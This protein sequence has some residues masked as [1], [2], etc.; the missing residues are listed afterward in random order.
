MCIKA[1]TLRVKCLAKAER[2]LSAR[3][4]VRTD[5]NG[6][7]CALLKVQ[8]AQPNAEFKGLTV[9]TVAYKTSEYQ[10][11]L[12]PLAKNIRISL[13]GY[14]PLDV[15]FN[16]YGYPKL[17]SRSTYIMVVELP[18]NEN[19]QHNPGLY[20]LSCIDLFKYLKKKEYSNLEIWV[21][22]YEIYCNKLFDLLNN[23]NV[24]QAREDGKGHICIAGL[25]EK[26]AKNLNELMA[27]ID[28][29]LSHRKAGITGANLDSSRS[30]AILQIAL[31]TVDKEPYS[32]ISF[33]DLAGSER[34]VDTIDTTKQ[35]KIDGAEINK[36]LLALKECIRALD[37]EKRHKPFRGSK[38]TLVLRDSFIGDCQTLMIANI[39]PCLSCSLHTLN[40]LRYAD[41]VKELRKPRH[42][43]EKE[44]ETEYFNEKKKKEKDIFAD[45]IN[46]PKSNDQNVK[47]K[48][49]L[50][51]SATN[52]NSQPNNLIMD[53]NY[54]FLKIKANKNINILDVDKDIQK[55]DKNIIKIDDIIKNGK[56][57]SKYEFKKN[58]RNSSENKKNQIIF[59]NI[60]N[61][62]I[63]NEDNNAK[64]QYIIM[65]KEKENGLS[66]GEIRDK[67]HDNNKITNSIY[68]SS[69]K[70]KESELL[71]NIENDELNIDNYVSKYN[72]I[73]IKDDEDYRQ[74]SSIHEKLINNIL[75][76]EDIFISDH[77]THIDSMVESIK[78]EMKFLHEVDKPGSDIEEY[79]SNLDKLLI[80]EIKKIA[81]LRTKLNKFRI[82]LKDEETLANI[83]DDEVI[84]STSDG[85]KSFNEQ[86][87][88]SL[89]DDLGNEGIPNKPKYKFEKK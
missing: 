13:Q 22:F 65:N 17:D 61:N 85:R 23:K 20:L 32:K 15:V 67:Y 2:D 60:I 44:R 84:L 29:G 75:K 7:D 81:Q 24:L 10:V 49:E 77:K 71:K 48:I 16:D 3:I 78:D 56:I 58:K 45:L 62:Y 50:K 25:I 36:S 28:H 35:N 80:N 21:S 53:H 66:K 86:S 4:N 89:I 14:L 55:P 51:R 26:N 40:T 52:A 74:L 59:N 30:H 1:Q 82:M 33:I 70:E 27:L 18:N 46:M 11:Y 9:G 31:K 57:P 12:S 41:R 43:R 87:Q 19:G 88:E 42:E 39:S 73:E 34:A 5:N 68:S 38:L 76:E 63:N 6:Q 64:E 47:Y 79:T 37:M 69:K 72:N 8:L 54:N 83:V